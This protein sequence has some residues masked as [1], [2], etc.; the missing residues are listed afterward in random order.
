LLWIGFIACGAVAV[1]GLTV[2]AI[3][4]TGPGLFLFLVSCVGIFTYR[5]DVSLSERT[6]PS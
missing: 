4:H 2:L 5:Y 1:F 6:P 3:G